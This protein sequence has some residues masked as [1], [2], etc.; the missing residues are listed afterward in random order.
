MIGSQGR[1]SQLDHRPAHGHHQARLVRLYRRRHHLQL[2]PAEARRQSRLFET[3]TSLRSTVRS[4]RPEHANRTE[5]AALINTLTMTASGPQLTGGIREGVRSSLKATSCLQRRTKSP[6]SNR[7]TTSVSCLIE[8][9][10]TSLFTK[11]RRV[12]ILVCASA[13]AGRRRK[14]LPWRWS[15]AWR[16]PLMSFRPSAGARA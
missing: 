10:S 4:T 12:G 3:V 5:P 1:D 15:T 9:G 8:Q 7:S 13:S 6:W 16:Q 2:Q 14:T 11:A